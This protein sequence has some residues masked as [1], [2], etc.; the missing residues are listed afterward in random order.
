MTTLKRPRHSSIETIT[1]I[2]LFERKEKHLLF[3]R[4]GR[5][6]E[7]GSHPWPDWINLWHTFAFEITSFNITVKWLKNALSMHFCHR[8]FKLK[9]LDTAKLTKYGSKQQ[10]SDSGYCLKVPFPVHKIGFKSCK[11]SLRSKVPLKKH[12][13]QW[14]VGGWEVNQCGKTDRLKDMFADALAIRR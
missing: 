10:N 8:Y 2:L 13:S 3:G 6:G 9:K 7:R 11:H 12:K 1:C 14:W 5:E 4:L